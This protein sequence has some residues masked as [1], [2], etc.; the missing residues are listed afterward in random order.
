M[1]ILPAT[2]KP[3]DKPVDSRGV[4]IHAKIHS[5]IALVGQVFAGVTIM[6]LEKRVSK[7]HIWVSFWR[8]ESENVAEGE[9]MAK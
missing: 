2:G 1:W 3:P 6:K 9:V 5:D 8:V 4:G 7:C